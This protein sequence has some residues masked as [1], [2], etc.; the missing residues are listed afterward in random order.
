MAP[1]YR[2]LRKGTKL[3]KKQH[4]PF[5]VKAR[6]L[7]RPAPCSIAVSPEGTPPEEIEF[8]KD[9]EAKGLI[10]NVIW[11]SSSPNTFDER[12]KFALAFLHSQVAE[13]L[14]CRMTK[15]YD[16]AWIKIALDRGP[17]PKRYLS[18]RFL[19]TPKFV[20][21]IISLGVTDIAGS[22]TL[23][24]FI[25]QA[26]WHS[27]CNKISFPKVFLSNLEIKRRNRIILKFLEIM[28]EV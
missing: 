25:A 24:K 8:L 4:P 27:D 12:M 10:S 18:Q 17:I 16:Y 13:S 21:Y 1:K 9:A 3:K 5:E 6:R 23:N 22:K 15:G 14:G 7:R 20:Y 28:N 26:K 2:I 11:I 19:S